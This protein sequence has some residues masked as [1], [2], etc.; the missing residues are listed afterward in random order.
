MVV[1]GGHRKPEVH[2]ELAAWEVV[3]AALAGDGPPVVGRCDACGQPMLADQAPVP[4][5]RWEVQLPHGRILVEGEALTQDGA[6]TTV[7]AV[8]AKVDTA[9]RERFQPGQAV[10]S[11]TLLTVMSVP[12]VL[13]GIALFVVLWFLF[14]ILRGGVGL[15]P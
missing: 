4:V 8:S 15:V 12:M 7:E 6:P 5:A 10:F 2:P 9:Y 11:G 14:N 13:W 1:A 3:K